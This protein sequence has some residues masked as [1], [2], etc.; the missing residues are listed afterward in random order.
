[1]AQAKPLLR[2]NGSKARK[3][4]TK[5]S[6]KKTTLQPLG[7]LKVSRLSSR[8]AAPRVSMVKAGGYTVF[9]SPVQPVHLTVAQ[10]ADAIAELD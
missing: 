4:V 9:G 6:A 8:E 3:A 1:M 7:S 5:V 10:I 2:S